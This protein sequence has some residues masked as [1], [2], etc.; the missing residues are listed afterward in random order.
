MY[1]QSR[2]SITLSL[3]LALFLLFTS[4]LVAAGAGKS[5]VKLDQGRSPRNSGDVSV[6]GVDF[7]GMV[8]FETGFTFADTEV[9]GLS[10]ITYDPRREV[11]YTISD[12]PSLIDPARFYTMAIDVA[13]GQ[14]N[15]GDVTFLDVTTLLNED[16]Q[17]FAPNA[18]DPEGIVLGSQGYLFV[19]SEG[20]SATAPPVDPFIYRYN[21]NGRQTVT[22]PIPH[23]FL[24]RPDQ[25]VRQNLAFE[26]LTVTPD[27]RYLFT[28][29][30]GALVQDGPAADLGQETLTRIIQ[31]DARQ[32]RALHE[33]VYV[34]DPV[35][36]TP[37]PPDAF[38]VSG[39]VEL[40]ALDN[41]G[42]FLVME[43]SFSVGA[44]NTVKLYEANIDGAT[45][46][47][48][49]P[50]LVDPG[51]GETLSFVPLQKHLLLDF[52][53]LGIVP[54][55]IEGMTLGP[56]LPDGRHTLLIVSDNNFAA[57][58]VTQVIALA[59]TLE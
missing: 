27:H 25:G 17:P 42:S 33:Y 44:G 5:P 45:D 21:L 32:R 16:G 50:A 54:D 10:S 55:N 15:G 40:L 6:A 48:D 43:R 34:A 37:D 19:S 35:V 29:N 57:E 53:D 31:Y 58:Q 38:R 4:A 51:T 11:Y 22:L 47:A 12:D 7:L 56:T 30:E 20:F 24:P 59:L 23:K 52:A 13:D 2:P 39:V 18:L 46:V 3:A 14:L 36:E 8:T 28:V 9:G 26:S 1:R 49:L 41:Q